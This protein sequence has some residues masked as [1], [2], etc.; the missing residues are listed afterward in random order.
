MTFQPSRTPL[1]GPYLP[2]ST[3]LFHPSPLPGFLCFLLLVPEELRQALCLFWQFMVGMLRSSG[4]DQLCCHSQYQQ[5][6]AGTLQ[7]WLFTPIAQRDCQYYS[8]EGNI[9]PNTSKYKNSPTYYCDSST[10]SSLRHFGHKRNGLTQQKKI[11]LNFLAKHSWGTD[12]AKY[13]WINS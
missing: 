5:G 2:S 11:L 4:A 13:L 12:S 10:A 8:T 7:G 9:S 1:G 3:A 6:A